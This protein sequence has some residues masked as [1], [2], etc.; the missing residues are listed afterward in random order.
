LR[1][2]MRRT[3]DAQRPPTPASTVM[4]V[5]GR[6]QDKTRADHESAAVLV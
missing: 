3:L 4:A 1:R 5:V 2:L 6:K